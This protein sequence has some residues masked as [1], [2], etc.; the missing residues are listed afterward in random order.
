MRAEG[1]GVPVGRA[2]VPAQAFRRRRSAARRG[3]RRAAV[4]SA[5]VASSAQPQT[6]VQ[7]FH[8][9]HRNTLAPMQTEIP[10]AQCAAMTVRYYAS[11]ADVPRERQG[12]I[13]IAV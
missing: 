10:S 3:W 6:K 1:A 9:P 5:T 11:A 12:E 13:Q 7:W 8:A 4:Q 2:R